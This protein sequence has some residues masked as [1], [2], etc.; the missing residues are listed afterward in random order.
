M[1]QVG[2]AGVGGHRQGPRAP[3][4]LCLPGRPCW[5]AGRS[6]AGG[7]RQVR[8]QVGRAR[9]ALRDSSVWVLTGLAGRVLMAKETCIYL[10]PH[11][12]QRVQKGKNRRLR[13]C[14]FRQWHAPQNSIP[15]TPPG[16]A[17]G[18]RS[19]ALNPITS[20]KHTSSHVYEH[21][22]QIKVLERNIPDFQVTIIA[23]YMP[24]IMR[25]HTEIWI[26]N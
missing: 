7:L 12:V 5:P 24:V 25:A 14:R 4:G 17:H 9:G 1:D 6:G 20:A 13:H 11:C 2:G 3:R 15:R 10:P 19:G 16:G 18:F 8:R 26:A 23:S 22:P 21:S